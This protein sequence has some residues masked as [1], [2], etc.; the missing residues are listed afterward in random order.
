MLALVVGDFSGAKVELRVPL[1]RQHAEIREGDEAGL[2]HSF[3]FSSFNFKRYSSISSLKPLKSQLIHCDQAVWERVAWLS[4]WLRRARMRAP[5]HSEQTV[6]EV[7]L[8]SGPEPRWRWWWGAMRII[9]RASRQCG[10]RT[11]RR[12]ACGW[13][14]I[15]SWT[16]GPW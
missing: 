15:R 16:G 6:R 5:V 7:E 8:A 11:F 3:P 14:S 13:G 12:A 9:S 1:Q 4:R 10:R 2:G